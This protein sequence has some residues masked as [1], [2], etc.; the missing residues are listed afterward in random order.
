LKL[1]PQGQA[2]VRNSPASFFEVGRITNVL[3]DLL[4]GVLDLSQTAGQDRLRNITGRVAEM[5]NL[6]K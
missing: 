5:R 1:F 3:T 6:L 2:N 4:Q